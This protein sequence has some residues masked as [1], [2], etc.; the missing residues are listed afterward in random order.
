MP[1]THHVLHDAQGINWE[2]GLTGE[3]HLQIVLVCF[4]YVLSPVLLQ[5]RGSRLGILCSPLDAQQWHE[6]RPSA[7][8]WRMWP[9]LPKGVSCGIE[10]MAGNEGGWP[11][12]FP[13]HAGVV[14]LLFPHRQHHQAKTW[15]P[16]SPASSRQLPAPQ[17]SCLHGSP[18]VPDVALLDLPERA[19]IGW[20]ADDQSKRQGVRAGSVD[21]SLGVTGELR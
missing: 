20:R 11:V 13:L 5:R 16:P 8:I 18:T 2:S 15:P 3:Q 17:P 6:Q 14:G 10:L 4:K 19:S 21:R 1:G 12:D 9:R 7:T